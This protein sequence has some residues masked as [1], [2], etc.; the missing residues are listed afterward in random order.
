MCHDGLRSTAVARG[1]NDWR[2]RFFRQRLRQTLQRQFEHPI[3]PLDRN[4]LEFALD[5]VRDFGEIADVFFRNQNSGKPAAYG[6]QELFLQTTDRQNFAAQ[7]D[8]TGH[9]HIAAH[10]DTGQNGDERR[11]QTDTG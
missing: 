11:A 3:D 10:G 5:V 8:F 4:N 2:P 7:R 9:C 1:R 6:G